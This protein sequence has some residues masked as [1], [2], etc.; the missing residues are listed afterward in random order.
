MIRRVGLTAFMMLAL[1]GCSSTQIDRIGSLSGKKKSEDKSDTQ[2]KAK[3]HALTDEEALAFLTDHC[4]SCHGKGA[5]LHSTW[6]MPDKENL[7]VDNLLG[8]D[9]M[10]T[11]YQ[12]LVNKFT[13]APS[14]HRP[15]P[16]PPSSM[17]GAKRDAL[18]GLIFWFQLRM[19]AVVKEA[20]DVYGASEQFG[21][22]LPVNLN[23]QCGSRTSARNYMFRLF[24][25]AL[26]RVPTEEELDEHLPKKERDEP[27]SDARRTKLAKLVTDG[28][29]KDG[30]F[31]YGLKIFAQRVGGAGSIKPAA[32]FGI[33]EAAAEDLKEEFYRLLLKYGE[34]LSYKDILLLDKV[35]VTANTFAFYADHGAKCDNPGQSTWSECT[36]SEARGNFFGSVGFLKSAPSSFLASNNN[37]KRGGEIHAIMRGERLMAQTDGPVGEKIAKIPECLTTD[38]HRIVLGDP[39]KPDGLRAPRGAVAV[40]R[41]GMICQGCHLQKQLAVASFVFRPFDEH[42]MAITPDRLNT[43]DKNPL[44]AQVKM[45]TGPEIQ[46]DHDGLTPVTIDTLKQLL[47]ET[48]GGEAQCLPGRGRD[49]DSKTAKNIGELVKIMIGDGNV[50]VH[51]LARFIP[52]AL[53]NTPVTN[54]EIIGVMSRGFSKGD[55]KLLPVFR[56]YFES[57]TFSCAVGGGQDE[58]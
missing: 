45:A 40:P 1:A 17:T 26:G 3:A 8:M 44:G 6:P 36:L 18:E 2:S 25:Q 51:G 7:T 20:E 34:D 50:L 5:D 52:S 31:A 41:Q 22:T 28:E 29:L 42:G 30:F 57:E 48:E 9:S 43:D 33:S 13:K 32:E 12:S 47:A 21:S 53:S 37:Y 55:G 19:P 14:G 58:E 24:N 49:D 16:M 4:Q 10:T 27:I 38:D 39:T 11:A 15:S 46:N 35:Q 56:S 23:F 54:Q